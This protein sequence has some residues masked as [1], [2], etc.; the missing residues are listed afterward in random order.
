MAV[1]PSP[2]V[3]DGEGADL[4]VSAT[5][6]DNAGNAAT[7][8]VGGIDIDRTPPVIAWSGATTY[9]VDQTLAIT[10]T[11]TDALSGVAAASCPTASGPATTAGTFTL[12]AT[13][14][15]VAGNVAESSFTYTVDVT[16]TTLAALAQSYL[17][18]RAG[19]LVATLGAA[20][21]AEER[22]NEKAADNQLEAF[23]RQ[24]A[25]QAGKSL[26]TEEAATL[27]ALSL[28]L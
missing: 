10:C 21:T 15:D 19:G 14:S 7:G 23:R 9:T 11:V 12:T 27:T 28:D 4:A 26:T 18:G 25:A 2:S 22:G 17:D 24:V 16:F 20:M 8:V 6:T 13:A 5:A 1:C 3:V